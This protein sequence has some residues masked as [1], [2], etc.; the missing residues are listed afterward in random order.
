MKNFKIGTRLVMGFLMVA[1]LVAFSGIMGIKYTSEISSINKLMAEERVPQLKSGQELNI[2]QRAM[3]GNLL[4]L[5]LVRFRMENFRKYELRYTERYRDLQ[6]I[7]EAFISGNEEIG[8]K[9]ARKTESFLKES[10]K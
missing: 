8:L 1:A 6:K 4:E 3:R 2:L 10:E 5:T 7:L 9:A